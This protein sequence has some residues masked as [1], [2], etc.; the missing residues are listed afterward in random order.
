MADVFCPELLTQTATYWGWSGG[1]GYGSR[2]FLAPV[3][4]DCHWEDAQELF[5]DK[6]GRQ[7]VSRAK[8]F[9]DRDLDMGGY[10]LLGA[11]SEADP[12]SVSGAFEIRQLAKVA[13]MGDEPVYVRTAIL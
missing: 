3:Q 5:I 1:D 6:D 9:V 7:V 10:L 13:G 12:R 11:S 2:T 8:V 4:I